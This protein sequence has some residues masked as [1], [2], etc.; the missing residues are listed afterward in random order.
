[1]NI[2]SLF[3]HVYISHPSFSCICLSKKECFVKATKIEC[4]QKHFYDFLRLLYGIDYHKDEL[5]LFILLR[6][7]FHYHSFCNFYMSFYSSI[8]I[9]FW[10]DS[11]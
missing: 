1:M 4:T 6:Y 8:A 9:H 10:V 7:I 5:I 11:F 2:N 3:M